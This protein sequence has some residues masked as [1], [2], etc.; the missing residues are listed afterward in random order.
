MR[1]PLITH[2]TCENIEGQRANCLWIEMESSVTDNIS[3]TKDVI[4]CVY[5]EFKLSS[6]HIDH[7]VFLSK[8]EVF[9]EEM[10]FSFAASYIKNAD[11]SHRDNNLPS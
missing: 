11:F 9:E 1:L 10:E 3:L 4:M 2:L 5:L 8:Y 6:S 7:L